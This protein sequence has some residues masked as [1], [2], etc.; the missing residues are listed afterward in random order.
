MIWRLNDLK[1]LLIRLSILILESNQVPRFRTSQDGA[2]WESPTDKVLMLLTFWSCRRIP[3]RRHSVLSEFSFNLSECIHW[4]ISAIHDSMAVITAVSSKSFPDLNENTI[5]V[6]VFPEW[7][8]IVS[9]K[10][11]LTAQA[12]FLLPNMAHHLCQN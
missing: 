8:S 6:H 2:I 3:I 12:S 9:K 4:L 5:Q 1:V 11:H 10:I 7:V